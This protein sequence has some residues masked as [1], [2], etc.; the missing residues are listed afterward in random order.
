MVV[1]IAMQSR[2]RYVILA[3]RYS[4]TLG[5]MLQ[6][7]LFSRF[8]STPAVVAVSPC[9]RCF[10]GSPRDFRWTEVHCPGCSM[11]TLLS[12]EAREVLATAPL[13]P[14]LVLH[15]DSLAGV[16][17]PRALKI[18]RS[19]RGRVGQRFE[20]ARVWVRIPHL[21]IHPTY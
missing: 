14:E 2:T 6:H 9:W 3:T 13:R 19:D 16:C 20:R 18:R 21:V 4:G 8:I 15:E 5:W 11:T 1:L 10:A 12:P 17:Y 7:V